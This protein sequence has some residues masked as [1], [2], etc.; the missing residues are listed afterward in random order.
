V[1]Q[2]YI[3][4]IV[5][6]LGAMV[7]GILVMKNQKPI[8]AVEL[9]TFAMWCGAIITGIFMLGS[10]LSLGRKTGQETNALYVGI[11]GVYLGL[12]AI[13]TTWATLKRLRLKPPSAPNVQP[14]EVNTS[15]Q[16]FGSK[17]G[18]G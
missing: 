11:F 5:S 6:A 16:D 4:L 2:A 13:Q 17:V 8:D 12:L 14:A 10:S 9:L 15:Q 7:Y 18:K 3:T 1:S